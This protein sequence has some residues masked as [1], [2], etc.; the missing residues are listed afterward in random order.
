MTYV[1]KTI[2]RIQVITKVGGYKIRW[3]Q[4]YHQHTIYNI[5]SIFAF[6]IM[7]RVL[8]FYQKQNLW[9]FNTILGLTMKAAVFES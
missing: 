1:H 6:N 4:K 7:L 8:V 2:G 5:P 3:V 9:T